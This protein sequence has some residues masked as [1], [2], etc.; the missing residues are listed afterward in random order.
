MAKRIGRTYFYVVTIFSLIILVYSAWILVQTV[1]QQPTAKPE[2]M[3]FGLFAGGL[4]I[5]LAL[6]SLMRVR[7][8]IVLL[9]KENL[10]MYTVVKC[11][12][13]DFKIIRDF[14][15]G[16]YVHKEVGDCQ[17]CGGKMAIT[18]IY[19]QKPKGSKP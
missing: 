7:N 4:G 12:K 16:D 19:Q 3:Y 8:R 1:Q 18:S 5:L 14:A 15:V 17:Q 6:S 11:R 2:N 13:C 9:E 10:K